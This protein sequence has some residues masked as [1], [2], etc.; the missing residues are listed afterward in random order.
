[1]YCA[2][3]LDA[4]SRRVVGWSIDSRPST[5]LVTN[6]LG[7]AIDQR[8]PQGDTVIHSDQGT[9]GELKWLSQQLTREVFDGNNAGASARGTAVSRTDPVAGTTDG[10]VA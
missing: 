10:R 9:Q 5:A 1:V 8:R 4:L 6:A 7:M 3:V 2:V